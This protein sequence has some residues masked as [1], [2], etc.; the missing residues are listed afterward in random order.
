V[1]EGIELA[2]LD[3][4]GVL[5][6]G[7][8]PIGRPGTVVRRLRERVGK[9]LFIT[10]NAALSRDAYVRKLRR[11]GVRAAKSEI[12][13]SAYATALYLKNVGRARVLPVGERGMIQELQSNGVSITWDPL[14]ATH[15]V[16]G[17]DRKLTYAKIALA[18]HAIFNGAKLIA[19]N[20]DA[21]YPTEKGPM[22]GAGAVVGAITGCTGRKPDV[23]IGKPS[24]YMLETALRLAGVP[25]RKAV[26]I[27]D[28]L[29]TDILAARRLG[30]R[31]ILVLTGITRK[32]DLVIRKIRP[33]HVAGSL[34]EVVG[35]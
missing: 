25:K 7:N 14:H 32:E 23:V 13:T 15:V 8:R 9:I 16:A 3:M 17:L 34:A 26:L 18:A 10:N 28:R 12:I 19:T 6:T 35:S 1:L 29:D 4:D 20:T 5:Y 30:I 11:M 21:T 22:P 33:D 24:T 2:M 27:G 31:S